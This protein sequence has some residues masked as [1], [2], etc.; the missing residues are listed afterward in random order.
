MSVSRYIPAFRYAPAET[1]DRT[2]RQLTAQ[3]SDRNEAYR[4]GQG[5]QKMPDYDYNSQPG[6]CNQQ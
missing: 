4:E 3:R 2:L 6:I 5:K 1:P